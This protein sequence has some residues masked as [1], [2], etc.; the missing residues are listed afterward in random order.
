MKKL[1]NN[2]TPSGPKKHD[3]LSKKN[4][5]SERKKSVGATS[6]VSRHH[7][8]GMNHLLGKAPTLKYTHADKSPY[9]TQETA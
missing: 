3:E 1:Q 6:G 8:Q 9:V 4:K 7:M 2:V 5:V